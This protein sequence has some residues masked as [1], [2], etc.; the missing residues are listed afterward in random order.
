LLESRDYQSVPRALPIA[1]GKDLEG[2]PVIA[3][4]A[5]MPHLLIAGATGRR[6]CA[7]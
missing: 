1:L 7:S 6:R 3:D 4:L 5:K 2:R